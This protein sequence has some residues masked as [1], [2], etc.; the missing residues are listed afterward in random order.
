MAS[1]SGC[2]CLP[3]P[4]GNAVFACSAAWPMSSQQA[5]KM[6]PSRPSGQSSVRLD[7]D[8]LLFMHGA[9]DKQLVVT[10]TATIDDYGPADETMVGHNTNMLEARD[11]ALG[12]GKWDGG[13]GVWRLELDN[14]DGLALSAYQEFRDRFRDGVLTLQAPQ[15]QDPMSIQG[16]WLKPYQNTLSRDQADQQ[17][18]VLAIHAKSFPKV[19]KSMPF[20]NEVVDRVKKV[21]LK[22]FRTEGRTNL[23]PVEYTFFCGTYSA[24]CTKF[25]QDTAEHPDDTLVFTTLTLL[26]VGS[27]SMCIAGKEETWLCKPFDTICF[28]PDLFHRSGET[29]EH[30]VKLSIHWRELS[31][32]VPKADATAKETAGEEEK[33]PVVKREKMEAAETG[34][35]EG[36]AEAGA[37]A[38]AEEGP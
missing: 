17:K 22:E 35:S 15:E 2:R 21:L 26:T 11:L 7:G 16:G 37:A 5:K 33:E 14:H 29:Y 8:M 4:L 27:T 6:R 32:A 20:L 10:P 28:D 12:A 31:K 30:I 24:S 13:C 38:M 18:S 34:E 23:K 1:F 19:K 3:P 25:H 36:E 9:T